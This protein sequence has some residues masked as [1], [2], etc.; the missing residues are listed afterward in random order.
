MTRYGTKVR[1]LELTS[2]MAEAYLD[3]RLAAR[4]LLRGDRQAA[5]RRGVET[6]RSAR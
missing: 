4:K 3:A 1:T 2:A 6:K 5:A